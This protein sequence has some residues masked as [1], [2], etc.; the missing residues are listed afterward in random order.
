MQ[1]LIC[2]D[3]GMARKQMV[4]ALPA[5]LTENVQ[6]AGNGQEALDIL[7]SQG[8]DLLLLDLTMPVMDGYQTLA[9]MQKRSIE[10]MTIVVSG[11]IQPEAQQRVTDLGALTFLKKPVNGEELQLVL[12]DYGIWLPH[13]SSDVAATIDRPDIEAAATNNSVETPEDCLR[14][15]AN[16]AMGQAA[17][18]LARLLGTFINLPIPRVAVMD[19]GELAMTMVALA[20]GQHIAVSQG[21]VGRG[22][23]AEA[24]LSTDAQGQEGLQQLML[25]H[26]Q[27]T[28]DREV[29]PVLDA[30]AILTGAF[31]TGIGKILDMDFSNSQPVL[32]SAN[33]YGV[34]DWREKISEVDD[35][36]TIEIPYHFEEQ[37][38]ICDLLILFP[39]NAGKLILERASYLL[40]D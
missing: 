31:L 4:R 25:S 9:E 17:D 19:R 15:V 36:L 35:T 3:S 11:D 7:E 27:Q 1:V 40:G 28:G 2:D 21:F 34:V 23:S 39:G 6:F 29:G 5:E 30:A 8:A 12:S 38:F 24:L 22:L 14:E 37:D 26:N 13:D 18:K 33:R 20:G 32:I 10:C 16:V